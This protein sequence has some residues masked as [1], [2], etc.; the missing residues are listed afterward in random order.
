MKTTRSITESVATV[1]GRIKSIYVSIYRIRFPILVQSEIDRKSETHAL[2]C[3]YRLV[4]PESMTLFNQYNKV[5][6]SEGDVMTISLAAS[7][8]TT[9]EA[10]TPRHRIT[11]QKYLPQQLANPDLFTFDASNQADFAVNSM[12]M[13]YPNR[14]TSRNKETRHQTPARRP[15]SQE[16]GRQY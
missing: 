5:V 10:T 7:F 8:I 11:E 13:G 16:R 3:L 1:L 14:D 15:R 12:K 9:N 4:S 6:Q 2:S